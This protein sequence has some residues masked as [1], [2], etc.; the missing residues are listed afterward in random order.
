MT[1]EDLFVRLVDNALDFLSRS[2]A[3]FERFPKYSVIHFYTAVEL[4]VKARLMTE[5]WSL[6]VSK[7]RDP[8]WAKFL[9][10]DFQSVSLDEAAT[11]LEKVVRS[12]LLGLEL[13]A[14]RDVRTHRNKMVH[15]FHEAHSAE[16]NGEL[17]R[18]IA[19]EQLIAWYLLHRLLTGRWKDVFDPWS[20]RIS[21][22]DAELRKY[23]TFLQVVFDHLQPE[24]DRLSGAGFSFRRCPSCGFASQQHDETVNHVYASTCL[25]CGLSQACL[26][27]QCLHC[28]E[29]VTFANEGFSR[30][31]SCGKSLEPDDVVE[32]LVDNDTAHF[33]A[34]DGDDSWDLGNCSDCD[35]YHT[36]V[37]VGET[38]VCASCLGEFNTLQT[39]GWCNE[40]NTGDMECSYFTGCNHCDGKAGW[41]KDD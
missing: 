25:V 1:S 33:A 30:C 35:G 11:R 40:P 24:I 15:L 3:D 28:E 5:H 32:V 37:R 41:E 21:E 17:R 8:D 19:K 7:Q 22:I 9:A 34:M 12:G 6:V 16:E 13:Q 2:I 38:H 29:L 23:H 4:F 27:I 39:C 31:D 26:T 18:T 10:G 20:R 36:V 14:F